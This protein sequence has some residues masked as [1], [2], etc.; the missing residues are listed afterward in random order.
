MDPVEA[1][2]VRAQLERLLNGATLRDSPTLQR[3]LRYIVGE[4]LAGNGK[5]LKEYNIGV[6]V[7]HRGDSFEPRTDSIVR[8]QVGVLRKKLAAHYDDPEHGAELRIDVP[9]GQYAAIFHTPVAAEVPPPLPGRRRWL[10]EALLIACGLLA[11]LTLWLPFHRTPAVSRDFPWRTHPLWRGFFDE[12]TTTQ[13]VMGVPLFFLMENMYVRDSM[14]NT[15]EELEKAE[16][17]QAL[18]KQLHVTTR[19]TEIYTG[20]GEAAGLYTLGRFFTQGGKDLP[21]VRNR[22]ARW[23]DLAHSNLIILSSFRFRTLDRELTVP[24]EFE[25]DSA[26]TLLRNLHPRAGE[27]AEYHPRMG[28]DRADHDYAL[29]STWPSPQSGRRIMVL[30]GIYTWGTQGAA[31]YVVDAPSLRDL[32]RRVEADRPAQS[33]GLQIVVKVLVRDRQPAAASYVTHRWIRP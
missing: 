4:T 21:L 33:E 1:E 27:E 19:P 26:R 6:Q 11:G 3:L 23:E 28:G 20:L 16:R 17:I 14:V 13:L 30:N 15:P 2:R 24:H 7:F 9:R 22:L 29:I 12:D 25:F 18:A 32:A 10:R 8:V 31:D 5:D